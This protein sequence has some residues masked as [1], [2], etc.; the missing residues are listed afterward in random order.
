MVRLVQNVFRSSIILQ[1]VNETFIVLI[2]KVTH[3]MFFKHLRPI[4][5]CNT[6]YKIISKII[7]MRI[8]PLLDR[9]V[10]PTQ[11][12]FV[13]E[14]WIGEN[15][16]L[17]NKIVH[18]MRRKKGD[19]R[20]VGIKIN[21]SRAYDRVEWNVLNGLLVQFGFSAKVLSLISECYIVN[22]S[23]VLLNVSV[24][25][26]VNMERG[27]RQGDPIALY[28]FIMMSELLSRMLMNLEFKGKIQRAWF[29]RTGP[30]ISHIFFSDDI[31]LF[32][33]ANL[34]NLVEIK[35]CLDQYCKWIGQD[36]NMDKLGCFFSNN[37]L[38]KTKVMVKQVLNMKEI[39]KDAKYL[40]NPLFVGKN[41]ASAF[42][43]LRS[44]LESR[45][46]GWKAKLLSRAGR[47]TL[48]KSV[49]TTMPAYVMT[50][51]KLSVSWCRDVDKLA[52]RF[53]WIG[54]AP[55]A[56]F[57]T[58]IGWNKICVPKACGGIG[59]RKLEDINKAMVCKLGWTLATEEDR[60]WV[61]AL[62]AKYF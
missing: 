22:S 14:R 24:F 56:L 27:L 33:H 49:I 1:S 4:S 30:A 42:E 23:A 7:A 48:V 5:L 60:L 59:F 34:E 29:G 20:L 50:L 58:L 28:L 36:I 13:P 45:I 3:V 52:R 46:M 26:R 32:Y 43:D 62:K 17:I 18:S 15:T 40:G 6:T 10:S 2:L 9:I 11:S 55:K 21:M 12:A 31:M 19:K 16:I 35:E 39:R 41:K 38:G 37:T 54:N 53:F 44:R 57:F 25:G 51:N 61:K 47:A 8:K